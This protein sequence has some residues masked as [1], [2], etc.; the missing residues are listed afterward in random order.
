VP[1]PDDTT[2]E[3]CDKTYMKTEPIEVTRTVWPGETYKWTVKMVAPSERRI[4]SSV[5]KMRSNSLDIE[6][7]DR[8]VCEVNVVNVGY[9]T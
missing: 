2:F 3:H 9:S 7:G 4:H 1:W 5:F 6:F 8:C